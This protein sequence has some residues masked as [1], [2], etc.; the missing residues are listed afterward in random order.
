M[1]GVIPSRWLSRNAWMRHCSL[2]KRHSSWN[3]KYR[4]VSSIVDYFIYCVWV[5]RV[6]R[7]EKYG[8]DPEF[9]N[10]TRERQ[11]WFRIMLAK[12]CCVQGRH[13]RGLGAVA[14]REKKKKEKKKKEKRKR[15]ERKKEGTMNNVKLLHIK[16]FFFQIFQKSSGIEKYKKNLV[17][18]PKKKLKWR[19]WL[20][21][22]LMMEERVKWYYRMKPFLLSR[23]KLRT[24]T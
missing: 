5:K 9:L 11:N 23:F 20:R 19:P 2:R 10:I 1:R 8:F 22:I 3:A 14:P 18:S 15:K 16:C 24:G 7:T 4:Q 13:L 17:P 12:H 6:P 21:Q